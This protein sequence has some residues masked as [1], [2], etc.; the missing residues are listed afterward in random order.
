MNVL[1]TNHIPSMDVDDVELDG[2]YEI[3]KGEVIECVRAF[4]SHPTKRRTSTSSSL[5]IQIKPQSS[6]GLPRVVQDGDCQGLG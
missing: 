2:S 5:P 4:P 1:T 6:A 3:S